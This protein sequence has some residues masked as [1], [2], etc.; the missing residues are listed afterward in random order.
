MKH[1][2]EYIVVG[3]GGLGSAAAYRLARE[4]G[5]EVLALEQF[6][7][8]HDNGASQDHS[9]IIRLSYHD[10][11]YTALT[12]HTYTAWGEVEEES[13]VQLVVKTGGLD[14]LGRR[15]PGWQV[16]DVDGRLGQPHP[17]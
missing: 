1:A 10:P 8:G 15:R 14:P 2:Y 6:R 12:P 4:A 16:R 9:R 11:A 5:E 7:L 17:Q 13:G 3:C